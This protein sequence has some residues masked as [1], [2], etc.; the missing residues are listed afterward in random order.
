MELETVGPIEDFFW[1]YGP[2]LA[3]V[4]MWI[5]FTVG[6]GLCV[7]A[8]RATRSKGY[9][10]IGI[11]FLGPFLTFIQQRVSYQLHKEEINAHAAVRNQV[12]QEMRERGEPIVVDESVNMSL[13]ETFLVLGLCFV[14]RGQQNSA[15]KPV[16][17]TTANAAAPDL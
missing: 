5:V 17:V 7:W 9:L 4:Y 6:L 3:R 11:F 1:R 16:Q 12:L 10:L 2:D 13:M 8:F 15:N 14:I